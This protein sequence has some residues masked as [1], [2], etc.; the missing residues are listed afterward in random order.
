MLNA[1][2]HEIAAPLVSGAGVFT[3]FLATILFLSL[4]SSF[5]FRRRRNG[6]LAYRRNRLSQG[7]GQSVSD[8]MRLGNRRGNRG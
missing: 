7:L 8:G 2:I 1:N 5:A 3:L 4:L 6:L